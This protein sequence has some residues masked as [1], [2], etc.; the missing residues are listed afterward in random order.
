M[1]GAIESGTGS[2]FSISCFLACFLSAFLA[3]VAKPPILPA[4]ALALSLQS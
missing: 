2:A 4:S 3:A 1:G